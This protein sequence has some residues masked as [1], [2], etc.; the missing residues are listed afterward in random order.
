MLFEM[1]LLKYDT[2]DLTDA[3][4]CSRPI[5]FSLF[6]L[7]VVFICMNMFISIQLKIFRNELINY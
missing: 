4:T 2:S 3:A 7:F 6:I 5:C 1:I